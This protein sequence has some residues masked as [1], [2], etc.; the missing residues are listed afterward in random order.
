MGTRGENS[1]EKAKNAILLL[2][3]DRKKR[4]RPEFIEEL[5]KKRKEFAKNTV[6]KY[7]EELVTDKLMKMEP[8]SR[9]DSF[10]PVYSITELGLE[11]VNRIESHNFID[12][13]ETKWLSAIK[14]MLSGLLSKFKEVGWNADRFMESQGFMVIPTKRP[15]RPGVRPAIFQNLVFFPLEEKALLDIVKYLKK[16]QWIH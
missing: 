16:E 4:K 12:S 5:V 13:F 11:K 6:Y 10:K 1:R 2:A 15:P 7:L 8:G 3:G 14:T 9:E